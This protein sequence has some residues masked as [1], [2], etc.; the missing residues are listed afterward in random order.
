[1]FFQLFFWLLKLP[2]E[3]ANTSCC[4]IK[5]SCMQ[6]FRLRIHDGFIK[7]TKTNKNH[8]ESLPASWLFVGDTNSA[9][10][11]NKTSINPGFGQTEKPQGLGWHSLFHSVPGCCAANAVSKE[12][13]TFALIHALDY[14]SYRARDAQTAYRVHREVSYCI[15]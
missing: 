6:E 9:S 11:W 14:C 3:L 4:S 2:A 15:T 10:E 12:N 1:M 5:I 13:E 7:T 8:Q